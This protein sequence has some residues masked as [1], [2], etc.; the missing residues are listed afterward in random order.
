MPV[1]QQRERRRVS[2]QNRADEHRIRHLHRVGTFAPGPASRLTDQGTSMM[3]VVPPK[4]S[5][6]EGVPG[7]ANHGPSFT[8]RLT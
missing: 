4:S 8:R 1:Y 2:C 3:P 5:G 7:G 6:T